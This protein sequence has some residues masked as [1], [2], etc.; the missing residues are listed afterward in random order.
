MSAH[1][2]Q[3]RIDHVVVISKCIYIYAR[4]AGGAARP[5]DQSAPDPGTSAN[6]NIHCSG[7]VAGLDGSD[8]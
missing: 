5:F 6:P 1:S 2:S 4:G 3:Y 7:T 8:T